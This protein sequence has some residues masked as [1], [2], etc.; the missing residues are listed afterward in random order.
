MNMFRA[1]SILFTFITSFLD[2][3]TLIYIIASHLFEFSF[4]PRLVR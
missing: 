4:I 1:V 2:M 3:G